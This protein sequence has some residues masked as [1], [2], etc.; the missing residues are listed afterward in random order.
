MI[1]V[2]PV[3]DKIELEAIYNKY[4]KPM[5]ENSGAVIARLGE[6]PL[7]CCLFELDDEKIIITSLGPLED[8]LL[9]DGILRSAL[10]IA[11]FRGISSAFYSDSAPETLF[12]TL[13]FIKNEQ[14]K[15]LRI[16]KL[17]QSSCGCEK[18][19]K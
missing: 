14:E 17:H 11:D 19:N 10:H 9:A 8:V 7:G 5:G 1:A 6:M 3:K 13:G 16:E 18:N 15:S 4:G 2:L 12:R